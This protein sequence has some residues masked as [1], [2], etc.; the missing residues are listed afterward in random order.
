MA[1]HR[2]QAQEQLH[3]IGEGVKGLM[4]EKG[5]SASQVLAVATLLPI[6][7]VLLALSG[8]TLAGTVIGLAV[9]APLFIIFSPVLVPAAIVVT[10]AVTGFLASGAFTL[11]G[12]S[13]ISWLVNYLRGLRERARGTWRK[14]RGACTRRR[15]TWS[16][17]P[18]RRPEDPEQGAGRRRR[19]RREDVKGGTASWRLREVKR[20]LPLR[21]VG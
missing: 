21:V 13:S 19:R 14:L 10:L 2:T 20:F 3:H 9:T 17:E 15:D 7:G 12:L 8:A 11:T 6:G 18:R 1:E 5:P 4:P 16:S